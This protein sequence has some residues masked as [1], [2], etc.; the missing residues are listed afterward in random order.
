MAEEA[1]R[2][3]VFIAEEAL[4]R[5]HVRH[6]SS[7]AVTYGDVSAYSLIGAASIDRNRGKS[8]P[9]IGFYKE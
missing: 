2:L 5:D 4:G 1:H 3:A 8:D 7:H 9:P 6:Y